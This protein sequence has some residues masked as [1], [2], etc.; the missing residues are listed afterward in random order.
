MDRSTTHNLTGSPAVL[1]EINTVRLLN[2]LRF[3]GPAS[4]AQLARHTGLDAKTITNLSNRLLKDKLIKDALPGW[5]QGYKEDVFSKHVGQGKHNFPFNS[6]EYTNPES[7]KYE[8]LTMHVAATYEANTFI[9]VS[10]D[11]RRRSHAPDRRRH[12]GSLSRI[13]KV[14][15]HEHSEF[16]LWRNGHYAI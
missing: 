3:S 13:Q 14:G 7:V 6:T 4:R 5:P 11:A 9:T 10:P 1:K 2:V 16:R 8:G 12:Q 15:N